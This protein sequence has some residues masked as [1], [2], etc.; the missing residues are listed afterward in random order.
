MT[1]TIGGLMRA[2]FLIALT[3]LST[4]ALRAT[5]SVTLS[6]SPAGP[7]PVGTIIT[8]TA[9]VQDTESGEHE[10]R[11]SVGPA[12]GS[13]AIVY[14]FGQSNTFP[15]AFSQTEGTYK[16]SVV[17]K[18][19][20]NN[21]TAQATHNFVVTTRLRGGLDSVTST[22]NP[23]VA[24]FSA[25]TC[26]PGNFIRV[27]FNQAGSSVSQTTNSIPCSHTN[28]SNF[29]IAGMYPNSQYQ[30]HHETMTATGTILHVG[31]TLTFNTG[32]LPTTLY[33]PSN[34][35]PTPAVP[36]GSTTA[37]ILLHAY[38]PVTGLKVVQSA[39]DLSGN[40]LWYYHLPVGALTR[41]EVGGKM[42]V[43]DSKSTNLY[44]NVLQEIDLAGNVTLESNVHR[45][46][47]QLAAM[48]DPITGN[49]RRQVNQFDHEIRR[50]SNGNIVVKA[51]S[52]MVVSAAQYPAQCGTTTGT[53]DVIGAQ[54]LIL[55][56]QTVVW[57]CGIA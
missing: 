19:T 44:N 16:V 32:S 25:Q 11:Y 47:E 57:A 55:N 26:V 20:S 56:L 37:P 10:Y 34:T 8:W 50:L 15:W 33:F 6:P 31:S 53:C 51:S 27:R 22:A 21:T 28:S 18:N 42:F 5:I 12:G 36:P 1:K 2:L 23:L 45:V 24:L 52:E 43:F 14:D 17:A 40:V 9:T 38:L 48:T 7:Q 49:P 39:T 35:V 29:Y 54:V 41:T 30:M 3:F 4:G 13:T 46:N